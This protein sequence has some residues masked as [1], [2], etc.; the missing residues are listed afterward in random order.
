MLHAAIGY[1][2]DEIGVD[3]DA[4]ALD[5]SFCSNLQHKT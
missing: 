3:E 4:E 1:S 2:M 5:Q